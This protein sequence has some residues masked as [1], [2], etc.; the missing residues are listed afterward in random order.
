MIQCQELRIEGATEGQW[1]LDVWWHSR[2]YIGVESRKV[3]RKVEKYNRLVNI[4]NFI[5][6]P[7][8]NL[9]YSDLVCSKVNALQ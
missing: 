1:R 5:Y 4:R 3:G 2:L 8:T 7:I 9:S 6:C